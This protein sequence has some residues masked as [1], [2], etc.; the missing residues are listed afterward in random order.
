METLPADERDFRF[1]REILTTT[2]EVNAWLPRRTVPEAERVLLLPVV[3]KNIF[4]TCFQ[5]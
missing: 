5:F 2:V 1:S 3:S 4:D